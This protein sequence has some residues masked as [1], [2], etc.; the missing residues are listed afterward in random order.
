[1]QAITTLKQ[2]SVLSG[3]SI[4]TVSKA[5]NDKYDV[6]KAT[7]V[8]IQEL[9]RDYNYIPNNAA[10]ALRK[11]KSKTLAIIVPQITKSVIGNL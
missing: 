10:V 8:K 9:A 6:S 7:R 5:L 4:S 3:C 11:K 2:M 1:M